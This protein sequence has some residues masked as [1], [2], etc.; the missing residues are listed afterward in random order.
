MER[1]QDRYQRLCRMLEQVGKLDHNRRHQHSDRAIVQVLV[2]AALHDRPITWA[3][4][5][6]NWVR[7]LRP[8][9]LPGQ[10]CMSRRLR[11]LSIQQLLERAFGHLREQLP[12]G[13][14]KCIDAKPLPVGGCSK[15]SEAR[16]GRA[17]S[18][19]AKG[20]KLFALMDWASGAIDRW[21]VGGMN[22]SE[23]KAADVLLSKLP[24]SVAV[25]GDGEY[26]ASRLHDLVAGQEC[27]LLTPAPPQGGGSGHHY[28][29]PHRLNSLALAQSS[30]GAQMLAARIVIEQ[31]FG[32]MTSFAG[33]LG[34]LPA[35]VRTPHRVVAWVAAKILINLDRQ[36]QLHLRRE[37]T[38]H[39]A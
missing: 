29:S 1:E 24:E 19:K 15:D 18:C 9:V 34:P 26:D 31:S 3:C 37:Q 7:S 23:Q 35:W 32:N 16:Y 36:I 4:D 11:T 28:Q 20:Y 2:W 22:W 6:G 17:A 13:M 30:A 5:P 38:P 14:L 25:I 39:A 21:I 12:S 33:G 27:A 8:K 10:S